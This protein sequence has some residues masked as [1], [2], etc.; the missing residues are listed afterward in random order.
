[1]DGQRQCDCPDEESPQH[2]CHGSSIAGHQG[3][4]VVSR[5][6]SCIAR[7]SVAREVP[8]GAV[9]GTRARILV[10]SAVHL[11]GLSSD[12]LQ[13]IRGESTWAE[14]RVYVIA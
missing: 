3:T 12:A 11:R 13:A 7:R 4:S 1:L 2:A 14:G 10:P 6:A 8:M 5:R 9:P